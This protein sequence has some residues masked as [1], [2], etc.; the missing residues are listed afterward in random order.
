MAANKYTPSTPDEQ[1]FMALV[2]QVN[3]EDRERVLR[4]MRRR[5]RTA[6]REGR[7]TSRRGSTDRCSDRSVP[8]AYDPASLPACASEPSARFAK[9]AVNRPIGLRASIIRVRYARDS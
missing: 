8:P 9:T 5:V 1:E 4:E 6:K 2:K 7:A 3:P